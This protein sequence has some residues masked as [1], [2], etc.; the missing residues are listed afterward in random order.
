MAEFCGN[1]IPDAGRRGEW[2]WPH[3]VAAPTIGV[4]GRST[5]GGLCDR[6]IDNIAF[7]QVS[8]GHFNPLI[9]LLPYLSGFTPSKLQQL[10]ISPL[11]V[12]GGN[13]GSADSGF[14]VLGAFGPSSVTPFDDPWTRH[15]RVHRLGRT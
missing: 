2:D 15:E 1:A 8:G 5:G 10:C 6:R 3:G 12:A 14:N 7:G 11:K 13:R 9:T 4:M